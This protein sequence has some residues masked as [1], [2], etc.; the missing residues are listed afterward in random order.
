MKKEK[1]EK[2]HI[3]LLKLLKDFDKLCTVNKINY[4][5]F[6]GTLIGAIR[7]N[8]FIP[9]DDD[10]DIIMERQDYDMLLKVLPEEFEV[11]RYPWVPRF[12]SKTN[13]LFVDLFVFDHTSNN[14]NL[15]KL[16][17]LEL[18][19]LQGTLKN[20][21]NFKKGGLVL[22][23]LSV[24]TYLVGL[25]FSKTFKLK[26]YDSIATKYNFHNTNYILSTLDQFRYIHKI[27]PSSV[28]KS[29]INVPFVDT[30]LKIMQGYDIYLKMFYGDYMQ[31]PPEHLQKPEHGNV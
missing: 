15:Q 12:K 7:H 17:V 11:I 13:N 1:I 5:L 30:E 9:W 8:G 3:E 29:Y 19:L 28:I 6:G 16:H 23:A 10:A 18:K 24:I 26:I 27:L 21:I 31:L 2:L 4:S 22:I 25:P 20:S 14:E